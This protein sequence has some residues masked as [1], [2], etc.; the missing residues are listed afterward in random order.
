MKLS[1][2]TQRKQMLNDEISHQIRQVI[3]RA[4]WN[5]NQKQTETGTFYSN[6]FKS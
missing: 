3:F 5:F 1:N 2:K 4:W 6:R